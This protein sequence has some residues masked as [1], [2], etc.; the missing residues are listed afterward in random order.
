MQFQEEE[1]ALR[2]EIRRIFEEKLNELQAK[3]KKKNNTAKDKEIDEQRAR[4][5]K[6]QYKRS[7]FTPS[8]FVHFVVILLST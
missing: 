5:S 6:V 7:S 8:T 2:E 4:L 3:Q 1:R